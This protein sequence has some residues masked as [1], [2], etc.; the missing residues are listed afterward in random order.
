MLPGG[1]VA[2]DVFQVGVGGLPSHACRFS[3][4]KAAKNAPANRK[5][6]VDKIAKE[7]GWPASSTLLV[8]TER[9]VAGILG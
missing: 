8:A 3:S 1:W 4:Q 9:G 6:P 2:V 5:E 7:F